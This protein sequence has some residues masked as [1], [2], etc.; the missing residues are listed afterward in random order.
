MNDEGLFNLAQFVLNTGHT[1]GQNVDVRSLLPHLSTVARNVSKL[2]DDQR[3]LLKEKIAEIKKNGF[4]ITCDLWTDNFLKTSYLGA[5]IHFIKNKAVVHKILAM[6]GMH[7]EK[8]TGMSGNGV[9]RKN[10]L[11]QAFS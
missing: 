10:F 5:T 1:H 11:F 3:V 2:Y 9:F 8:N 6:K 4:A 7:N